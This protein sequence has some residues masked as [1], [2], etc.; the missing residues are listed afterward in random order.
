MKHK[1]RQEAWWVH[2]WSAQLQQVYQPMR[3]RLPNKIVWSLVD[4]RK[5]DTHYTFYIL[6]RCTV[7]ALGT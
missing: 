1:M 2:D 7:D 4:L 3:L 5:V 6:V